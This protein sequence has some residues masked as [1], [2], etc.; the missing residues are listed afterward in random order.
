MF[1]LG[2]FTLGIGHF[3]R[4][5]ELTKNKIFAV[6]IRYDLTFHFYFIFLTVLMLSFIGV[7]LVSLS[8]SSSPSVDPTASVTS[9]TLPLWGDFLA[10]VSA[11]FYALYVT[12][13]KVKIESEERIDM[14]LFFG[15]VG[16]FNIFMSWPVGVI[17]H[18]TGVET[19]ESPHGYNIILGLL[20][21]VSLT[22]C[23]AA[24][25][26]GHSDVHHLVERLFIC[27]G[28]A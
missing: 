26:T 24:L 13:L 14:Q 11:V 10:L 4:V 2:F 15:F 23:C 5:E 3:F 28:H 12:L 6:F 7:L 18:W 25:L 21:N 9:G 17:L 16:L 22:G 8:D 19:F 1:Q 20:T 27:S